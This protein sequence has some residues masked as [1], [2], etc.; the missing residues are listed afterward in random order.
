MEKFDPLANKLINISNDDKNIPRLIDSAFV[1]LKQIQ[2]KPIFIEEIK[3]KH[4]PFN[5]IK[6]NWN[7]YHGYDGSQNG[8]TTDQGPSTGQ[9]A[10]KFPKTNGW[11]AAPILIGNTAYAVGAGSDVIA[12][13]FEAS[14]GKVLWK[15][16]QGSDSFYHNSGARYTP[17]IT[18]GKMIVRSGRNSYFFDLTTGNLE[19]SLKIEKNAKSNNKNG[20]YAFAVS[21]KYVVGAD[22]ITGELVWNVTPEAFISGEPVSDDTYTYLSGT[23][24]DYYKIN[25]ITGKTIWKKHLNVPLYGD[26]SIGKTLVYIQGKNG[27][28]FAIDKN[29]G[30]VSWEFNSKVPEERA[31]FYYSQGVEKNNVLY[32]GTASKKI[33]AINTLNGKLLWEVDTKDW[34]RSKP[35]LVNNNLYFASLSGEMVAI[36]ISGNTPKT[37]WSNKISDHGIMANLAGNKSIILA[38]DNNM[39]MHGINPNTGQEVWR[40]SVL[41]GQW[42]DNKFYA[43]D[44]ITGQQS[45]PTIVDDILYIAGPDGFLNAVDV[46][47]GKEKWKFELASNVSPSPT[48]AHGMVFVG[49]TYNSY[50]EYY[51]LDKNTGE[52]KWKTE[53]FGPVWISPVEANGLMFLGNMIG[54]FFAFDPLNGDIKWSYRTANDT[55]YKDKSLEFKSGHGWPPGV[56]CNPAVEGNVVYTGS[57]AGFYYAF[58]QKTGKLL[59]KSKTQPDSTLGG[60]PDSSAPVLH[61]NYLYVQKAGR[62]IA[63]INKNSGKIEWA[64]EA[65]VGFLQNGTVAAHGNMFFGS[66]VRQVTTLPYNATI[67]AFTDVENGG[68]LQWQY[69]GGGGLTAPVITKDKLVFGSSA[70]PFMTC[71]DPK[72]GNV[73]WRTY[74]GGIMLESVPAI[75]GNKV[76]ALIKNGYL[77][78]IK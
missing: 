2:E 28:L 15:G 20:T 29:D 43:S 34:I 51:A 24:G 60:L 17:E 50:N 3:G 41:D 74:V 18:D 30:S 53:A 5:N 68:K 25:K 76:Y 36:D 59:W 1:L 45:S 35:V 19:L 69:K 9:V 78:A 33:Y 37:M 16:Q 58:D 61:K 73:I 55:P 72:T 64:W 39:W 70:D 65:P 8:F 31:Y 26:L 67:F 38:I 56:Y 63:A 10:W 57:W 47:T 71:L 22:K 4:E 14:T 11:K 7:F 48:V 54:D 49:Q 13:S 77:Y 23:K 44:E 27:N 66:A 75:Y 12:Y 62:E 52:I 21:N 40:E 32:I 42:V 46:N 6:T